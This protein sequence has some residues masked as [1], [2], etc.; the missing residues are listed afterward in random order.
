[1]ARTRPPPSTPTAAGY[2]VLEL[3]DA[4][5]ARRSITPFHRGDTIFSQG[6]VSEHVMYIQ[7]GGVKLSVLS[8]SGREAVLAMLGP[9][10]FFGEGCLEGQSLRMGSASAIT[11]STIVLVRKRHMRD[12][13]RRHG[14]LSERFI[15]HVL[16][17]NI[18]IEE[19]LVDQLFDS[20]EKRLARALL[21][22]A[23]YESQAGAVHLAPAIPQATL[24]DMVGTT[25]SRVSFFLNRFK[26]LGFI[27]YDGKNTIKIRDSLLSVVLHD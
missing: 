16:T 15:S 13:L 6:D 17:R 1:M 18:R 14:A 9:G 2:D 11:P 4:V 22:L 19:D 24:A 27:D 12:L 23:R 21:L 8:T 3:L 10:D 5:G 26:K 25:R 7:T 20:S